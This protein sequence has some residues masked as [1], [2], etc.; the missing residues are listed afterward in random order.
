MHPA[1]RV[2]RTRIQAFTLIELLVV[3]A[4]ISILAAILFPVFAKAREKAR[5]IS[6]LSNQKQI[7]MA[8]RMY[9]NDNDGSMFHHHEGWVLNDG[10]QLD[11][12]TSLADCTGGGSGNS[13]A[14]KPWI[15]FFQP[16]L[17][18]RAVGFC[19]S[20]STARSQ[21][22][23]TDIIGYNGGIETG[24][25]VAGSEQAIAQDQHLVIE[26]YLLNSIFTHKSCRFSFSEN[27]NPPA[28]SGFATDAALQ[29]PDVIMFSERNSEAL[30]DAGNTAWGSANQDDYDTWVGEAALVRSGAATR[31]NDGWIKYNRHTEGSNYI[32][33]DGHAKWM[34]WSRART[35]Q[36]PDHIV[37]DP[38]PNP[39]S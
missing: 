15:I 6:C 22:L 11:N 39:P 19:P 21:K 18:S 5:Q 31:P 30:N 24:D 12:I 28:L 16:Y 1:T 23:A 29:D 3:I 27:G 10:T 33:L 7:G 4:I 35:E 26:S 14:E 17:K 38:L 37:R 34:R 13:Q 32:F 8:A 20:D 2:S 25:P 9:M 36:Y